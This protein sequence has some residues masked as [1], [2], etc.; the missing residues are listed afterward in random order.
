MELPPLLFFLTPRYDLARNAY[1][2]DLSRPGASR[3]VRHFQS[4]LRA[5]APLPAEL[6][7]DYT[8]PT[9]NG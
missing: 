6:Q 8:L 2:L 4:R 1:M 9:W 3:M 5:K 7:P